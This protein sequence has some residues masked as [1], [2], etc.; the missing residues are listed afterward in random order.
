MNSNVVS[1]RNTLTLTPKS[2]VKLN[3]YVPHI[4]QSSGHIK[5]TIT[6][7]RPKQ[8][9]GL[10][11]RNSC[12]SFINRKKA[13]EEHIR[14]CD[15]D[16]GHDSG[17]MGQPRG[18]WDPN[19]ARLEGSRQGR[20]QR[21]LPLSHRQIGAQRRAPLLKSPSQRPEDEVSA[22]ICLFQIQGRF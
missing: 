21:Q 19:S 8:V 4:N 9:W 22:G 17:A 10:E 5:L 16:S 2:N 1:S 7:P 20:G 6:I 11:M 15:S 3:T 13:L 18:S 12:R 14:P